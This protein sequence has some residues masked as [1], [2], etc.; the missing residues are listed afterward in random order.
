MT[1]PSSVSASFED[2]FP[3]DK[4]ILAG[5][6]GVGKTT[7]FLRFKKGSFQE[8]ITPGT[9]ASEHQKQWQRDGIDISVSNFIKQL[10]DIIKT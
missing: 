4:V 1:V 7:L 5:N 8:D 2:D 3:H 9:V 6:C 10:A